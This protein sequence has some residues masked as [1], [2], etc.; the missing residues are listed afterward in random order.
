MWCSYTHIRVYT[1]KFVWYCCQSVHTLHYRLPAQDSGGLLETGVAGEISLHCHDHQPGGGRE[2]KVPVLLAWE[3]TLW[4]WPIWGDQQILA[5]YTIRKLEAKVFFLS[6]PSL[7]EKCTQLKGDSSALLRVNHFHFT[8]WPDHGVPDY[9][10]PLLA[11][12]RQV[13]KEHKPR[14]GPMM[15]HCR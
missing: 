8:A 14:K 3:W 7:N 13:L 2:D 6:L 10:T 1:D 15:V 9:A 5:D 11:F 12:H 4:V